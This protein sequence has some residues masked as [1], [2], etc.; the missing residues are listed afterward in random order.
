MEYGSCPRLRLQDLTAKDIKDYVHNK[1]IENKRGRELQERDPVLFDLLTT[2][3]L[4]KSSGVFLWIVFAVRTLL[5]GLTNYDK[6]PD[7]QRRLR[8]LPP[9]LE[10]LYLLILQR[11]EPPF[12]RQQASRLLQIM[13]RSKKPLSALKMSFADEEYDSVVFET[14]IQP[15]DHFSEYDRIDE[16]EK[17]LSSRCLGLL[18]VRSCVFPNQ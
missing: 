11:I 8:D 13:Y 16:M 10:N 5:I 4:K 6:L 7:L 12:Y 17:R 3:I 1:F 18:E 15:I 14:P 2:E 9:E